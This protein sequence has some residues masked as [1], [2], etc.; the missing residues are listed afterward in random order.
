[1]ASTILYFC[2]RVR[3]A[4]LLYMH[5]ISSVEE[6]CC[7]GELANGLFICVSL[8]IVVDIETTNMHSLPHFVLRISYLLL[9]RLLF[10]AVRQL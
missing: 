1:M 5:D 9:F 6:E 8:S 7:L 4:Q 10:H 3:G 2:R